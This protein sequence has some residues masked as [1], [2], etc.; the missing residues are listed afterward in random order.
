MEGLIVSST[1]GLGIVNGS[2]LLLTLATIIHQLFLFITI[3]NKSDNHLQ[4]VLVIDKNMPSF[5]NG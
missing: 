1:I 3:Y 5:I 4:C 2:S